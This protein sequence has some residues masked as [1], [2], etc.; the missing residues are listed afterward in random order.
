MFTLFYVQARRGKFTDF[1]EMRESMN[2]LVES[3]GTKGAQGYVNTGR[4][5][6]PHQALQETGRAGAGGFVMDIS[7]AVPDNSAYAG[8]GRSMEELIRQVEQED[9][10]ARRNYMAVMAG[11][12]SD[13]DFARLQKEGFH[14]GSTDIETV[15]TIVDRI[16]VA[17]ARGGT[18]VAGYTDTV[19]DGALEE[20]AGSEAFARELKK[21]FE[22]KGVPL[23]QE[24]IASVTKAWKLLTQTGEP[25]EGSVKYMVENN[26]APDAENLYTAKYSSA[27]DADRQGKGYYAAGGVD[28]Y[29]ARKPEEIDFDKLRPQMEKVI[30]TAGYPV[31]QETLEDARWLVEKGIPL[32]EETF[33]RLQQ[34]RNHAYPVT[35]EDFLSSAACAVA[36]GIDPARAD[37]GRKETYVESALSVLEQ[38][39]AITSQAVDIIVARELPLT[40]RSLFAAQ[41]ELSAGPGRD[42]RSDS[43]GREP[44]GEE[45][46]RGRRLLEEVRLSMTVEANLRLL[47]RGFQIET[48][49][50]EKLVKKLREA[51][52]GLF[53][54][55]TGEVDTDRAREKASLY[56]ETLDV[57]KGIRSAPASLVARISVTYTLR[58]VH[59][60]GRQE[61][62]AMEKAGKSY[63]TMMTRPRRDMGDSMQKAFRNVD[64]VLEEMNLET[65]RENRRAVRILGYNSLEITEENINRI[66]EK[67]ELLRDVIKEMDPGRVLNMIR[68]GVNPLIMPLEEL[69]NYF[70]GQQR[71][72]AGEMESYSRFLYKLEK[73][74]GITEEEKSA[75]IGVYRLVRQLEKTEDAAVGA[76]W[77]SGADFTLGNLLRAMRSTKRTGMD[78]SIDDGFGGVE[79][80][81]SANESITSQ[82]ARGIPLEVLP[83]EQEVSQFLEEA[84][85]EL[86]GEEFDRMM[87]EQVRSAARSEAEVLQTLSDYEKP[88]T[89]DHL[90]A[91]AGF[92]K[93][94]GEIWKKA[95]RLKEKDTDSGKS[96][97]AEGEATP[98]QSGEE[99]I[100]ALDGRESAQKAYE[101][102]TKS[103]QGLLERMAFGSSAGAL[104]V[105][106]MSALYK[107]FSFMGS[108]AR[109]ENYEIPANIGGFL[110][111][112]NLKVIHSAGE[113][114]RVA[115]AFE[116]RSF[117]KT[118]AQFRLTARGLEGLCICSSEEGTGILR[119]SQT[120]LQ[121]MFKGEGLETGSI[122]FAR[123]EKLDLTEFALKASGARKKSAEEG[124]KPKTGED[125]G[126]LY[127]AARAFI[128]Y[129]QET[130]REKG[131]TENENQL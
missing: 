109:E 3:A 104:D 15:V 119:E 131:M 28:G 54:A 55:M 70:S 95:G 73:K 21:Q 39:S 6:A 71:D 118:A 112:I 66:R 20:I 72:P 10:T 30:A 1:R 7:G 122:Y 79:R 37:L 76:L 40:L 97:P 47:R 19:S 110:T 51:E 33:S 59:E 117:G 67:D 90:L 124:D 12:M 27:A 116:S 45:S 86:A 62:L 75:C 81:E 9:V 22:E 50:L 41:S 49:P 42:Y 2:I 130:G 58:E 94:P 48:A 96:V 14:P 106:A 128:G 113:E 126:A 35:E 24:N 108:M 18:Q 114:S 11:S 107:Q 64:D 4:E 26:L 53:R 78:Y 77:H 74:K 102:L 17:L 34:I 52:D 83:Q 85:E 36:D 69:G 129:V 99:V 56:E 82:I 46:L 80:K 57:L 32:N 93:D 91:A 111:S 92:L 125:S 89:A 87:Y 84:G 115:V 38:T 100:K 60:C 65:S 101:G 88:V 98:E 13:E 121:E 103:W 16:K 127:R 31:T 123:G 44:E 5:T 23:T 120:L 105:K 25:T 68:E 43:A 61:S 29:Y 63:E 8:H